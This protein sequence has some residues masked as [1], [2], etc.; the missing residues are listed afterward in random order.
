LAADCNQE[1]LQ[2]K[3]A[4]FLNPARRLWAIAPEKGWQDAGE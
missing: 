4:L 1:P 3:L 2:A